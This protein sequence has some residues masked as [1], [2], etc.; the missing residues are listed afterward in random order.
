MEISQTALQ[1]LYETDESNIYSQLSHQASQIESLRQLCCILV[2]IFLY[3]QT[4]DAE[5]HHLLCC[6]VRATHPENIKRLGLF[7]DSHPDKI[8][9]HRG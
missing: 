4:V 5:I 3:T 6:T 2:G 7:G 1:A 9:F 8:C